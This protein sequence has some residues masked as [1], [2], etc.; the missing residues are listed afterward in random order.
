LDAAS[1]RVVPA[2]VTRN[3]LSATGRRMGDTVTLAYG[4]AAIDLRITGTLARVP[5][6][7]SAS[8]AVLV[9]LPT[10]T[11]VLAGSVGPDQLVAPTHADEW[12]LEVPV[13]GVAA[14]RRAFAD[15]PDLGTPLDRRADAARAAAAP[16]GAG[17]QRS[18]LLL[19]ALA[20]LVAAGGFVLHVIAAGGGVRREVAVLC[21]LGASRRDASA[22]LVVEQALVVV[23]GV[24]LGV[25]LGVAVGALVVA[26]LVRTPGGD[27]PI[28]PVALQ[29]P[30]V[31]IASLAGALV[32]LLVLVAGAGMAGVL[33]N[34]GA[35]AELR[36]AP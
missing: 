21:A 14:V 19:A 22:W 12:W 32:L 1:R 25:A 31:P 4:G 24:V 26:D 8:G 2:L 6:V 9:D 20:G 28:L 27:V 11:A 23:V 36:D 34:R 30:V 13:S 5:S 15:H 3:L 33:R 7:P 16:L 18:L 10:L 35:G 17:S 29:V